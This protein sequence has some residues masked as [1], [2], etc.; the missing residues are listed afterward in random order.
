M[1]TPIDVGAAE[2]E[3]AVVEGSKHALVLVDF[4]APWCG[5]CRALSPVLEGLA[6]E[7]PGRL[8]VAKVNSD[9]HPELAARYG[10]RGIPNVKAFRDGQVVDEFT[11]AQPERV[12]RAFIERLLPSPAD[13]LRAEAAAAIRE[14]A[15]YDG[16]LASLAQAVALAPDDAEVRLDRAALLVDTGQY[17]EARREL[18]ALPPIV[19]MDASA[20][21]LEARIALAEGAA[22]APSEDVLRE[23]IARDGAALEA[24]MQLAHRRA[25]AGDY[26]EALEQLMEV[27]TRDRTHGDDAA[28][29]TM[30]RLFELLGSAHPLV[31]EFRRLLA[32]A[33]N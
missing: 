18:E 10:V 14:R 23:Q 11:G 1:T 5:P 20:S 17:A 12:V 7:Y 24:R 22:Q 28:R 27:V 2:F 32:S 33:M 25:A 26:R 19:R 4:W 15:D 29:K 8:V 13:E 3:T 31:R 21:L 6:A 16:A 9:D 30:L